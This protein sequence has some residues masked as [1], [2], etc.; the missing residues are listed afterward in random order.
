MTLTNV[1][2][3]IRDYRDSV[4]KGKEIK[5]REIRCRDALGINLTEYCKENGIEEVLYDGY[6]YHVNASRQLTITPF[7]G[8]VIID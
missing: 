7:N 1:A 4:D 3:H 8:E 5:K 2:A 6:I